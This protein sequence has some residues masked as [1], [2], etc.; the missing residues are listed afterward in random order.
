MLFF[1]SIKIIDG[2]ICNTELHLARI[3]RTL[4]TYKP[5]H[6]QMENLIFEIPEMYKVG[7][8]KC[9]ITY[10]FKIQNIEFKHYQKKIITHYTIVKDDKMSYAFKF[11]DRSQIDFHKQQVNDNTEIIITKNG[12][13][14][15]AS[16]ANICF[17][18]GREWHTPKYPLLRGTKRTQLIAEKKIFEKNILLED[19][20]NY[21]QL[22]FINALLDLE[23]MTLPIY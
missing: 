18:T 19:I 12:L 23:E 20:K 13:V 5:L 9:K 17:W 21:K 14:T 15:D 22:C 7:L 6:A 16:Y 10:D 2:T 11:L 8:V 3:N 1:E 4:K